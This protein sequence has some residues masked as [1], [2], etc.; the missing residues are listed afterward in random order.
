MQQFIQFPVF[1]HAVHTNYHADSH[2]QPKKPECFF[3]APSSYKPE[4]NIHVRRYRLV[5]A[6]LMI[7]CVPP[8]RVIVVLMVFPM[9]RLVP[10]TVRLVP[11][12]CGPRSG[13]TPVTLGDTLVN[14]I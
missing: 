7:H 1:T 11:P 12:A 8:T 14:S 13:N 5:S 3:L 2:K 10:Y 9:S 4:D 6:Y